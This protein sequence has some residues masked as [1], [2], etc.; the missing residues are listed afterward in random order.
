MFSV[1]FLICRRKSSSNQS[2]LEAQADHR[3][4]EDETIQSEF[5]AVKDTVVE[6]SHGTFADCFKQ[7]RNRNLHRTLLGYVNQTFQ[8]ISGI[9]IIT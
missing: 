4:S 5:S 7:N 3:C 9:N 2:I 6:M 8:Q 1:R